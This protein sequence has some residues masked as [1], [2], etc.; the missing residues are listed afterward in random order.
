MFNMFYY[1]L[2]LIYNYSVML[3]L[4]LKRVL[5]WLF[6]VSRFL[7]FQNLLMSIKDFFKKKKKKKLIYIFRYDFLN[8][9]L[10]CIFKSNFLN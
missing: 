9:K 1:F 7:K 8:K 6:I 3:E 4:F 10:I 5:R 2:F